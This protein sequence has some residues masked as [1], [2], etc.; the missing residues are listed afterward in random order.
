[1]EWLP[2]GDNTVKN[3][4]GLTPNARSTMRQLYGAR[5]VARKEIDKKVQKMTHKGVIE[6]ENAFEHH[7]WCWSRD[8]M[9]HERSA[10]TIAD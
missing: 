10:S 2:S 3:H 8:P 7:Q 6:P 9:G 4:I 5:P 1:M